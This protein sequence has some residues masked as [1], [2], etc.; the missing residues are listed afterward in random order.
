MHKELNSVIEFMESL[1]SDI[2]GEIS[3]V[4]GGPG[5]YEDIWQHENGG[6]GRSRVLQNGL[7]FEKA[8][9]NFSHV[10]GDKLPASATAKRDN[11]SGKPFEASGV[12]LVIHPLN[13]FVP[14]THMNVRLFVADPD[15]ETPVWWFGGGYDLTP[16][17]PFDA[18]CR[19]WHQTA[20]EVCDLFDQQY[21][22]RFKQ[23]CDEYFYLNHREETR[24]IG[25]LFFDDFCEGGFDRAFDFVKSVGSSFTRAYIPIV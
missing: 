6:G 11:I 10:K 17:Y 8:G 18:D 16:Y 4:D 23:W 22:A 7:V 15:G 9:V 5:F 12:S 14:T 20:K 1:Q 21:Y 3:N 2:C 25:G 19:H 24:G 13:P